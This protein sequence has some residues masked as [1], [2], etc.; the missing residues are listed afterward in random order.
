MMLLEPLDSQ[1]F[2]NIS[3]TLT[4]DMV[5]YMEK[6]GAIIM[7]MPKQLWNSQGRRLFQD[8]FDNFIVVYDFT[9]KVFHLKTEGEVIGLPQ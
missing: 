9:D 7:G 4:A 5:F 2:T 1:V 8:S 6:P 3:Y